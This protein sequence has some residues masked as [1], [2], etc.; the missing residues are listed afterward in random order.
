M[1]TPDSGP[2]NEAVLT[3][4]ASVADAF[5]KSGVNADLNFGVASGI[6]I[7]NA[8]TTAP[9]NS[10]N[11]YVRF[12]LAGVSSNVNSARLR[13]FGKAATSTKS[14]AVH[15][16]TNT[17]WI[18]S[19]AGGITWN[20]APV[21]GAALG[22]VTVGLAD[23]WWEWDVTS[24]VQAQKAAGATAVSFGV[25]TVPVSNETQTTFH[26]RENTNDPVLVIGSTQ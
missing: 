23:A 8:P 14:T 24:F 15:E 7:K 16:V 4:N 9:D 20:N 6:E 12:S 1:G 5:V 26:A 25:K 21:M 22:T 2:S 3:V 13:F 17:T 18:E 19:G 11:G 10:R